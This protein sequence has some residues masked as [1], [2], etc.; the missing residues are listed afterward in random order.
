MLLINYKFL[1]CLAFVFVRNSELLSAFCTA[2]CQHATAVSGSH[3][4]A[5]AV[6]VDS[7]AV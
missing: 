1:V 4:V 5:K 3:S 2:S 6:F 7:L